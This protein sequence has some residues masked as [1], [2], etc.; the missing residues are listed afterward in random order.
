[1][2]SLFDKYEVY[3]AYGNVVSIEMQKALEPIFEKWAKKG[4]KVNDIQAIVNDNTFSMGAI[5]RIK[6]RISEAKKK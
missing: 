4:Y 2:K 5:I 1:M 3:N 6:R